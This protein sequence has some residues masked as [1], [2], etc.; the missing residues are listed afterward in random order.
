MPDPLTKTSAPA[1]ATAPML[2]TLIPPSTSSSAARPFWIINPRISRNF[3]K[4]FRDQFLAPEPGVYAHDQNQIRII[5]SRLT[6]QTGVE[7][8]RETPARSPSLRISV[9]VRWRWTTASTCTVRISAPAAANSARKSSGPSI[10]RWTSRG[11]PVQ[12]RIALT[13]GGPMV[14]LGTK[15]PSMT[16]T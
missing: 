10:I 14:K 7:G 5:E 13:T 1:P 6:R 15:W 3:G 12:R 9:R 11:R 4:D 8:F 16:S 2:S